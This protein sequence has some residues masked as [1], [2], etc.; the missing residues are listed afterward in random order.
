MA[1]RSGR[2]HKFKVGETLNL[3]PSRWSM[4]AD[5]RECKVVRLLPSD[6]GEKLYRVKCPSEPF[7]RNV[8]ES[9]LLSAGSA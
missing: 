8:R 7:E 1:D 3:S 6:A 2:A 5:S 4:R 9:E